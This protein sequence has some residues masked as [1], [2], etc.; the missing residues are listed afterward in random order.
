MDDLVTYMA[1]EWLLVEDGVVTIG[2][3]E[4][5][6][7]ELSEIGKINLPSVDDEVNTEEICGEIETDSGPLNLYSPVDGQIVEINEAVIEDPNL[8]IEDPYGD[9]WLFKVEAKDAKEL[10]EILSASTNDSD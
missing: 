8:I 9:G 3:N 1:Y 5:G 7:E 2:I 10:D 6:L 4:D